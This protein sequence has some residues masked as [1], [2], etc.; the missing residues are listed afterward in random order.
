MLPLTG[1]K[2][3]RPKAISYVLVG[4]LAAALIGP[5]IARNTVDLLPGSLY[6]GCFFTVAVVQLVSLVALAG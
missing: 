5:E 6:A 2:R 1:W 4:G 3:D